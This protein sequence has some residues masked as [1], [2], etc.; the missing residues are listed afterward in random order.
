MYD[1]NPIRNSY[2]HPDRWGLLPVAPFRKVHDIYSLGVVLL[3]I[4]FWKPVADLV[5]TILRNKGAVAE[6][7][8][9]EWLLLA[10]HEDVAGSMGEKFAAI[11]VTCLTGS[12]ISFGVNEGQDT[13]ED[14]LLQ[15]AFQKYVVYV[16]A[17][18]LASL[19]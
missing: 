10:R 14:S 18:S 9:R 16:F 4:A 15:G 2:R 8:H 11:I 5:R 7:V 12:T 3:E 13:R 6:D 1:E 19:I 17:E